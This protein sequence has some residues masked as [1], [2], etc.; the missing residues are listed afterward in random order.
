M[1]SVT[2]SHW[3]TVK[4]ILLSFL[5]AMGLWYVVIG[6]AQVEAQVDVRVDYRGLPEG[7]VVRD[8]MVNRLSVRLRGPGELL[9]GLHSRDLSYTVDLSGV[10]KGANVLPLS[11]DTLTD[12][13]AYEVVDVAPSRLV[14]EVD[15]LTE[16]V[17]P[18][19]VNITPLPDAAPLRLT[20]VLLEPSF[21][22]VK[23]PESQVKPLEHLSV[24]FDPN[25]DMSEGTRA[26]NVAI[27][28]PDRVEITPPVT[29]LRYTLAL[30]TT[31]LELRRVVQLDA[32]ERARYNVVP[33]TVDLTVEVPEGR[34][35]DAEYQ[36]AIRVVVRPP[37]LAQTGD[38]A[39]APVLVVLPA[40]ARLVRVTPS[41]VTLT[42]VESAATPEAAEQAVEDV[43]PQEDKG[44][45]EGEGNNGAV[46][47]PAPSPNGSGAAVN[48]HDLGTRGNQG[49]RVDS[50]ARLPLSPVQAT[51]VSTPS[52]AP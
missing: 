37:R 20:H 49:N 14:L 15:A 40:G 41:A 19:E 8:G 13:K 34:V 27:A 44:Q 29:T 9:R 51:R 11:V 52:S 33:R 7:L 12:L 16:R 21:V 17:L 2:D 23:G 10:K 6:S 31:E 25:Q 42:R 46:R 38:S 30:K 4:Y 47:G 45:T 22:T 5:F 1:S 36:A 35:R 26:V 43:A 50:A 24:A 48:L 39:E 32:E 3:Q 28:G 18:L